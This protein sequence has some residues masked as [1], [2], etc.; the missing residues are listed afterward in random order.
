[1][2]A[3]VLYKARQS[4][5]IEELEMPEVHDE[6]VLIRVACCGVCHTDLKVMEGRTRFTDYEKLSVR[7][8]Q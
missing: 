8:D 7:S 4:L 6:A 5:R 2:K 1:M 3:A